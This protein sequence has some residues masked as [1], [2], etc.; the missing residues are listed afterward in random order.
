MKQPILLAGL[1]VSSLALAD[2]KHYTLA[3]LK[4]LVQQKSYDEALD[5]AGDVAPADRNAD[6]NAVVGQAAAGAVASQP[7][8]LLRLTVAIDIEKRF[9]V[10]LKSSAYLGVRTEVGPKGFE[11][12]FQDSYDPQA[13]RDYA[14]KFVDADPSNGK[15]ALAMAKIARRNMFSQNAIP[16]FTRAVAAGGAGA[17]KDADLEL[18]VVAALGLST[19]DALFTDARTIAAGSCWSDLAAP[20]VKALDHEDDTYIENACAL[21]KAKHQ[22]AKACSK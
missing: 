13:C 19:S 11:T 4:A 2:A 10:V 7:G 12:C 6:W 15:L 1:C 17:C 16:F 20:I 3:D 9:P 5:H 8:D 14:L 18:A 22:T 21:L